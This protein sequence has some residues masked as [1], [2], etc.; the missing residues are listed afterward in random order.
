MVTAGATGVVLFSAFAFNA[1]GLLFR[2][3]SRRLPYGAY[4][5]TMY[6]K[7]APRKANERSNYITAAKPNAFF[8]LSIFWSG[9]DHKLCPGLARILI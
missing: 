1:D 4:S 3:N 9:F 8:D 7:H 5:T 2:K 6:R